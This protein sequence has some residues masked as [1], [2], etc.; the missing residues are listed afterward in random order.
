MDLKSVL[1]ID[2]RAIQSRLQRIESSD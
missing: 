1:L 2:I